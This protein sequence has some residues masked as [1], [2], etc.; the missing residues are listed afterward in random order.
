ME[1]TMKRRSI[2]SISAKIA[3]RLALFGGAA[4]MQS[5][6]RRGVL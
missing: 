6:A 4:L 2:L 3:F 5:S 1:N